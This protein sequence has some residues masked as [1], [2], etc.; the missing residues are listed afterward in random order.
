MHGKYCLSNL[1]LENKAQFA[2]S[3]FG[4]KN[5][6]WKEI[7][8]APRHGIGTEKIAKTS[9][10]AALPLFITDEVINLIAFRYHGMQPMVGYRQRDIFYV[11]TMIL[12][13][14]TMG[15]TF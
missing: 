1:N 9:I 3:I 7:N 8:Q 12:H 14:T 6:I 10:R 2:E 13:S 5:V 11:L 4:R 15:K